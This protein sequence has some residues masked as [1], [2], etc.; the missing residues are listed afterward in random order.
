MY[1]CHACLQPVLTVGRGNGA[2]SKQAVIPRGGPAAQFAKLVLTPQLVQ[3]D[4]GRQIG[5][6][7]FKVRSGRSL[8]SQA[9]TSASIP[10]KRIVRA[11]AAISTESV[12]SILP[13]S[14]QSVL[15]T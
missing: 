3:T 15:V 11:R 2:V 12:V 9:K 8:S 10:C 1:R 14:V 5:H 4:R 6:V 13:S 7:V